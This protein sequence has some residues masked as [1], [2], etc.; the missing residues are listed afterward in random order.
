LC[1]ATAAKN[2]HIPIG[3]SREMSFAIIAVEIRQGFG[4]FCSLVEKQQ[5]Q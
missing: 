1:L 2:H 4:E 3:L 5:T